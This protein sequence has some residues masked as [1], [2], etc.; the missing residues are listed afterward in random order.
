MSRQRDLLYDA[1]RNFVTER[2]I[3]EITVYLPSPPAIN[4]IA[5]YKVDIPKQ[6][7]QYTEQ[8]KRGEEPTDEFLEAEFE[9]ITNGYWFFN[10][11]NLEYITGYHYFFLNYW[12]DRGKTL[13][14]IDAQRDAFLWWN[15]IEINHN[16]AFGN[17]VSNRRFGKALDVDTPIPTPNGWT[18]MGELKVG[19]FVFDSNG[20]PTKVLEVTPYQYN[21]T[22][23]DVRFSDGSNVIADEDHLW[24]AHN[25][26][27]RSRML[28]NP[29][30]SYTEIVSTK[31]ILESLR[32]NKNQETNWS[33]VNCKP[34]Q[35]QKRELKVPPYILGTWLGDGTSACTALTS[36]DEQVY[37]SWK[38]Y[39][40]ENDMLFNACP[41]NNRC[42]TY[43]ISGKFGAGQ[44]HT[45][46]FLHGLR[47]YNLIQNKHIPIDY[48]L[49]DEHD[50]MELLKGLMD[51]D[52]CV[53]SGGNCFEWCSK[54][55]S[56]AR[57]MKELAESLGYK[58]VFASKINKKYGTTFWYIRFGNTS[59]A[60]FKL[61][62]HLD[63]IKIN[64]RSGGIRY[65][66]RYIID[67]V[68][69][70]TRPVKCITVDSP[71]SSYLCANHIV[72]HN[73]VWGTCITYIRSATRKFQ[74]AGIQ[75]KTN[76][77]GKGVFNKLIGSWSKLP[78]WLK[79]LDTGETRPASVLEFFEAR[80]RSSKLKKVYGESLDSKID[81]KPSSVLAYDG[82]ELDTYFGDEEGKTLDANVKERH[83]VVTK[84]L[85][86]GPTIRGKG[87]KTT[88]V[89]EMEKKGGKNFKMIWDACS[90]KKVNEKTGRNP[91]LGTNL[92]IP[93]DYGYY[94]QHPV[95]NE[96]F[97]DE[98]GYSKRE[99]A[100]QYILDS[101]EGLEGD[102]LSSAQRKDPLNLKHVWQL[103]NFDSTFDNELLEHQKDY[104]ER[105]N[106][107]EEDNA[108]KN[109]IRVVTF[110][111][112]EDGMVKW[113]DDPKGFFKMVWD[114]PNPKQS[115]KIKPHES[116][117]MQPGNT[118]SYAIGVDPFA[119]TITT[120]TQKSMGVAY[121]YK[122]ADISDPENSG[123]CVVRYAQRTRY[124]RQFHANVMLL[125]QYFGCKA[126][127][128]SNVDD[129]YEEFI[130]QGFKHFV[131][132]RPKCT[133]D[134]QRKK[135]KVKYGTPSNDAFALQKQ[136]LI[137]DEYIKTRYHKIYFIE[138]VL[139][140]IE[141]DPDDR[142]K[143]DDAIAFMMAIIGGQESTGKTDDVK[144]LKMMEL[145]KSKKY[146]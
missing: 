138:L 123:F 57:Q 145:R 51:T 62:R 33:V 44:N 39:A 67:V 116:G 68:P 92:F 1:I 89:E 97:V 128:E 16:L 119:A 140:L 144:P 87:L 49:S 8:P 130:A 142:T 48:M 141:F 71:D 72:T 74:Y 59:V 133:I 107:N 121:V 17:L 117:L 6:K 77:D 26:R 115:N 78:E 104:L 110:Y 82:E 37:N 53:Y 80:K 14:F 2:V 108:P 93:A 46:H 81:F 13:V 143:S 105:T 94:G 66:H 54:W 61:Q 69:V 88:T 100:K 139:Q 50:R 56:L 52:G 125:C 65:D 29:E 131:M 25:K 41:Q 127:Y 32:V 34:L 21:R 134:P 15:Q 11:G 64:Q 70:E 58:V 42:T 43:R 102:D 85:M 122:K 55:E 126:N 4:K 10:N 132:W 36:V 99:L 9:K 38:T 63:K 83:D 73:T 129:Y 45:N 118:E 106:D 28:R 137:A 12:K 23:Y 27:S 30:L 90:M 3:G 20:K 22:C 47:H 75:S 7:F 111:K 124:K 76:T 91:G 35:Y 101:W 79:P 40:E 98:Y 96:W 136:T 114:F 5:N 84:C 112:D 103:K 135:F 18:T 120:G 24:I 19:D 109:L 60:P 146:Y 86:K 95:T 113:K 31:T